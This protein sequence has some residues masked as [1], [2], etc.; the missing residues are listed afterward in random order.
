MSAFKRHYV[1]DTDGCDWWTEPTF[2]KT[3]FINE[4][5]CPKCG[6]NIPKSSTRGNHLV[7]R[8]WVSTSKLFNPST[9]KTGYW[10]YK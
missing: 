6:S 9:W 8:K 7:N 1:C 4:E 3:F 5:C 10:V 2:G